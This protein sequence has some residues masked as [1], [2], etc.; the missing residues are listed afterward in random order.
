[1]MHFKRAIARRSPS[2]QFGVTVGEWAESRTIMMG[3]LDLAMMEF[4]E[5]RRD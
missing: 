4:V 3:E 5:G 2:F 1:M